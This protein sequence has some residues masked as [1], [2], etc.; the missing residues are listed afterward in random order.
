MGE[1]VIPNTITATMVDAA[2][3]ALFSK[4]ASAEKIEFDQLPAVI[5][6]EIKVLALAALEAAE[7]LRP[8]PES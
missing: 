2:A 3:R 1:L 6:Y 4:T 8:K 7:P 5:R